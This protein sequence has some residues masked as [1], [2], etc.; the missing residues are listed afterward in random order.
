MD[1]GNKGRGS[2]SKSCRLADAV[3]RTCAGN[4]VVIPN[5]TS[6]T[7]GVPDRRRDEDGAFV[8]VQ[9]NGNRQRCKI[10]SHTFVCEGVTIEDD[11][12]VG[13]GVMFINDRYPR[14]TT[15][16]RLQ[17]E[18]DWQVVPTIVRS[19]ASIGSGAV[20][21]CGVTIGFRAM[22]GA[23]AVVTRDVPTS[24]GGGRAARL[25]RTP[26]AGDRRRDRRI[27]RV[28]V[29]GY[30]YWCRIC[31]QL[32]RPA[33]MRGHGGCRPPPER[34]EIAARRCRAPTS[35]RCD[36]GHSSSRVDAVVIA[37]R[38]IAL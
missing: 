31:S 28:G 9:K 35:D 7:V 11:V 10:S 1:W 22:V 4:G 37:R 34:L 16:G 24:G 30:G 17:T 3:P 5:A 23:G 27:V 26:A 29:I 33:R 32:R 21:M 19:G 38:C 13:H 36:V 14:A 25:R 8:E 20:I 15:E 2:S 12:F 18:A 6:S